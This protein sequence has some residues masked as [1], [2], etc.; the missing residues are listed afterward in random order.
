MPEDSSARDARLAAEIDADVGVQ[1]IGSIYAEALLGA[2]ESAGSTEAVLAELDELITGVLNR[3]ADLEQVLSSRLISHDEKIGIIDRV[4]GDSVSEVVL[5][6]LKVVA[7]HERLDCLRAIHRQAHELYNKMRGRVE[8]SLAT[9]APIPSELA[10]QVAARLGEILDG[11]PILE[12][13]TD[14]NLIGGI[15]VRV[16]DTVYDGSIAT[17]LE[18][19]RQEIID[20]SAHEIQSRRDRFRYPA[21]N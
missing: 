5:S 20:R 2:A 16:G 21:G 11:E 18:N 7:R 6:F 17:Q 4:F 8:V 19:V 1:Q 3:Y 14:P 10:D 12:K 13:V 15:V 9:A